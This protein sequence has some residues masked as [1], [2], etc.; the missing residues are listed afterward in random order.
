MTYRPDRRRFLRDSALWAAAAP[1]W[2]HLAAGT[3][4]NPEAPKTELERG[5]LDPPDSARHWVY[6]MVMDGNLSRVPG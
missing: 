3:A 4:T 5:F 1:A 2:P 6:G